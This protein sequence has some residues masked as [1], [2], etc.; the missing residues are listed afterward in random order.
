[1]FLSTTQ[2][3]FFASFCVINTTISSFISETYHNKII[4]EIA[5]L[6]VHIHLLGLE[7]FEHDLH[8]SHLS[9]FSN[10]VHVLK[11]LHLKILK[12]D[13]SQQKL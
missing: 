8:F 12:L 10:V 13:N 2:C 7:S 5:K 3:D 11:I 4:S 1:M 6:P 9:Q